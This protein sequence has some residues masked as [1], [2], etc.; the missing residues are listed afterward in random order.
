MKLISRD[1]FFIAILGAVLTVLLLSTAREKPK[2]MPAD[3]RH[4]SFAEVLAKGGDRAT[5]EKECVVCHDLKAI[6]LPAKHPPKGQCLIC[7]PAQRKEPL[8]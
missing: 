8:E 3:D 5:V 2:K 4:R 7:H 1:W 6:P